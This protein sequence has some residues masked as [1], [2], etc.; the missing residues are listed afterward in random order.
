[1][2]IFK[3]K[4]L[5]AFTRIVDFRLTKMFNIFAWRRTELSQRRKFTTGFTLIELLVVISIITFLSSV[6]LAE[7]QSTRK[8]AKISSTKQMALNMRTESE[9]YYSNNS[10]IFYTGFPV[11]TSGTISTDIQAGTGLGFLGSE[12]TVELIN[13]MR[14]QTGGSAFYMITSNSWA[15]SF[16]LTPLVFDNGIIK[17]LMLLHHS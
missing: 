4:N 3:N 9:V 12:K 6:I 7:M 16:D 1:M 2:N 11:L 8:K 14:R 5:R 13:A 10:W 15:I 17:K